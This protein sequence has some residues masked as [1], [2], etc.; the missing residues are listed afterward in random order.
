MCL[1]ANFIILNL[2]FVHIGNIELVCVNVCV[3]LKVIL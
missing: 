2:F 3:K 1:Y